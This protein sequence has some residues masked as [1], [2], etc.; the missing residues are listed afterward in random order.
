MLTFD[1]GYSTFYDQAWPVL[2][3][4]NQKATL[5]VIS[6]LVGNQAYLNWEQIIFLD[7][8]GIEIGGHTRTHPL[9]P[10]LK[11]VNAAAEINQDKQDIQARLGHSITSFCY[12][13]GKYNSQ[14]VQQVQ[15]AG[16]AAAVTMV[17]RKAASTD[18][19]LLLPRRGVYQNDPLIRFATLLQ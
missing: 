13:T 14:V 7:S 6:G 11:S 2:K 12:P 15:A 9:L 3:E 4:F 19:L 10:T 18:N 17:Q 8:Q 5:F 16:Y 1:D